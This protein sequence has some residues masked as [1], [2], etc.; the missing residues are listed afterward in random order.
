M[1]D[2]GARFLD[3]G[4]FSDYPKLK[5]G[6]KF[7]FDCNPRIECFNKCCNDVN[8]FLTPYDII[9]LRK[10]L[11]I[12]SSEFLARYTILPLANNLRHPIVMLKMDEETLNCPFL[13]KNGCSVYVDRPWSCRMFPIGI[14]SPNEFERNTSHEQEFYFL[15]KE[16]V[17]KGFNEKKEWTVE[18]WFTNQGIDEYIELGEM[19]KEISLHKFFLT[20]R[21]IEPVK[22]EMFYMVCYD[23]DKF[24]SFLFGSSFF[25]RFD[26]KE[27][28]QN[29][30]LQNDVELLKF[31]F[32]WL[33]FSVFGEKTFDLRKDYIK[34][35]LEGKMEAKIEG[36]FTN[37]K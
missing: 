8:I 10:A 24:R 1:F 11:E 9:R 16:D 27:D 2:K 4:K 31:G 13:T 35:A 23:I 28:Y 5:N 29:I 20:S 19:F 36:L 25:R 15:I 37:T 14:A 18:E 12:T 32:R 21:A 33:R 30:L 34:P 7:H 6:E 3:L 22:L 26:I 17:C